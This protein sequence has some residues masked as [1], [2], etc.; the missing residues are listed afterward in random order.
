MARNGAGT[1]SRVTDRS[2]VGGLRE[3]K[4]RRTRA[5]IHDA[6]LHLAAEMGLDRVT[7]E[8]I[9]AEA[10]ISPRTFFNYYSSKSA[11]VLGVTVD[12][13]GEE[14]RA[15][16]LAGTGNPVGELCDLLATHVAVPPDIGPLRLLVADHP[17]LLDDV[18]P[19][20][21]AIRKDL[22]ALAAQRC[23]D[24]RTAE[25]AVSLVLTAFGVVIHSGSSPVDDLAES[26][27]R[28]VRDIGRLGTE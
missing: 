16:F 3:R 5:T 1:P 17:A 15:G 21:S 4:K 6:A 7:V 2:E 18:G 27:R 20:M 12:P 11:A 8:E 10:D 25:L 13:L 9:S 23:G 26:L 24:E 22:M 19:Q 28:T 14:E